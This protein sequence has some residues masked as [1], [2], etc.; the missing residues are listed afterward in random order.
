MMRKTGPSVDE[1]S[2][3]VGPAG[4]ACCLRPGT[5]RLRDLPLHTAAERRGPAAT[6]RIAAADIAA[7]VGG[8]RRWSR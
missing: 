4:P 2:G 7:T 6:E 5:V 3:M 8:H 1:K